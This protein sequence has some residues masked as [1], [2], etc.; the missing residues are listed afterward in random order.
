MKQDDKKKV[1]IK[2]RLNGFEISNFSSDKSPVRFSRRTKGD[3]DITTGLSVDKTKNILQIL[4]VAKL[5][6]ITKGKSYPIFSIKTKTSFG[7]DKLAEYVSNEKVV[8][9]PDDFLHL[10]FQ[11]AYSSTRGAFSALGKG[12]IPL[13]MCLPLVSIKKLIPRKPL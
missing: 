3:F 12:I 11:I 7:I 10:M 8:N 13:H 6:I 9:L 1:E 5:K 4:V 2:F